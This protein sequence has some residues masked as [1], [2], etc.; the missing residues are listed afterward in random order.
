MTSNAVVV[1]TWGEDRDGL[2]GGVEEPLTLGRKLSASL[3]TDLE[4]LVLGPLPEAVP[5]T[6]GRYGVAGIQ[7]IGDAKLDSFQADPC[8][9]ALAQY[10]AQR[11]PKLMLFPQ[12]LDSRLAAPRLAGRLGA[13]VVING[14]D[15]EADADGGIR[16]TASAYG[17][18]TRVVYELAGGALRVV[19]VMNNVS[20]P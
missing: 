7:R 9:E 11:S 10:C 15:L 19:T 5:E 14:V 3:G 4:W 16:I 12:H 8:V 1:C 18:D 17:G 2:P 13:A 20:S 6:A